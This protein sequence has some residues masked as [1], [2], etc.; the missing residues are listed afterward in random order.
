MTAAGVLQAGELVELSNTNEENPLA[1]LVRVTEAGTDSVQVLYATIPTQPEMLAC[2]GDSQHCS[3][4]NWQ[5]SY[6]ETRKV[7]SGV[8]T[9]PLFQV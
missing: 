7:T 8:P 1:W 5:H 9:V 2:C 6:L 4:L 3:L